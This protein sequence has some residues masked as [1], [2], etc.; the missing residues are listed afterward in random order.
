LAAW[1]G[2][3]GNIKYPYRPRRLDY[4]QVL[5]YEDRSVKEI[6]KYYIQLINI[7][8]MLSI[9]FSLIASSYFLYNIYEEL[10]YKQE[11]DLSGRVNINIEDYSSIYEFFEEMNKTL[12]RIN[13]NVSIISS[14]I[15]YIYVDIGKDYINKE[16][17][18]FLLERKGD[19]NRDEY[20]SGHIEKAIKNRKK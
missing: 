11:R 13:N 10:G 14:S 4:V 1:S 17:I 5:E 15:G 16:Y 20:V 9:S 18:K 19:E 7:I 12:D 8:L 6:P 3:A 2:V